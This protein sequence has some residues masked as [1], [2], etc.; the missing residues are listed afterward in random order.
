MLKQQF[1]FSLISLFLLLTFPVMA[2]DY[3]ESKNPVIG[4]IGA[5]YIDPEA[6]YGNGA[7]LTALNGS[8]YRGLAD[9]LKAFSILSVEGPVF[10]EAAQ[11]GATS[12]GALGFDS[13][14][15]QA[16]KLYE[17]TTMWVDGSHLKAVIIDLFND[18]L[19]TAYGPLCTREDIDN[20]LVKNVTQ[21]INYLQQRG[22]KV[23]VN[24]LVDYDKLDLPLAEEIFKVITPH[25][26]VAS[27]E[28]YNLL[29]H[30]YEDSISQIDGVIMLDTWRSFAHFGDG[31]HPNHATKLKAAQY[32]MYQV[33]RHLN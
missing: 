17:H 22:V 5:S 20:T 25:F 24:R 28:Q 33:Y 14:Q 18:C 9:Y 3:S 1:F 6:A 19:H 23:F 31:L 29:K 8:S 2:K 13:A 11:G 32:V 4:L 27:R 10:R 16:I 7:G 15:L 21:A 26:R 30:T 12:S